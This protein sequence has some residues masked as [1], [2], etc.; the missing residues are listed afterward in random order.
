MHWCYE[1]F[2][3]EVGLYGNVFLRDFY[4]FH[5]VA[6]KDTW[7]CNFWELGQHL[8]VKVIL[9]EDAQIQPVCKGDCS[10]IEV[11][12]SIGYSGHTLIVL[13][14]MKNYYNVLHL[15]DLM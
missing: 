14:V 5:F 8:G 1:N 10:L 4:R 11:F 9:H 2:L 3:V 6:T 7:F 13:S 12:E 15:L